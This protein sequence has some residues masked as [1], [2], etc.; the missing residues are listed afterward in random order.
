M[1]LP[2]TS[3]LPV[4]LDQCPEVVQAQRR[5]VRLLRRS[6]AGT[7]A[8]EVAR[9]IAGSWWDQPWAIEEQ[10]WP[11]RLEATRPDDADP[12]WWKV[13]ARDLITYPETV[14]VARVL[15]SPHW[16]QQTITQSRGH[17]PYRLGKMPALLTELADQLGRP[18]IAHHL[19]AVT[20]G[21]LF[22]WA[23][24]RVRAQ[25]APEP[26]ALNTATSQLP[27][28]PGTTTTPWACGCSANA[29]A[30]S[31]APEPVCRPHP[32]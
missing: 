27:V 1:F 12:G 32:T 20:H 5:R 25:T 4:P 28:T 6:P 3:G 13:A 29:T 22:T 26:G 2:G 24:S 15:A 17:L 23:H 10:R 11:A 9:A 18:W 31:N 8:F 7:Q 16:Q 21:P 30:P 14:A 19:A